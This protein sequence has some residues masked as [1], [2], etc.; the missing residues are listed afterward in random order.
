MFG[1]LAQEPP[2]SYEFRLCAVLDPVVAS[3]GSHLARDALPA[4]AVD[5]DKAGQA[6][7][8]V[9]QKPPPQ[10]TSVSVPSLIALWQESQLL[11]PSAAVKQTLWRQS[12]PSTHFF[13]LSP[14]RAAAV[15]VGLLAAL[16][17]RRARDADVVEAVVAEAV[18]SGQAHQA[19]AGLL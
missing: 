19:V 5:V 9:G 7:R 4:Q 6:V 14:G 18:L 17:A 16:L 12:V 10:F 15:H 13:P 11:A 2:Q 3:Q 1:H 8:E